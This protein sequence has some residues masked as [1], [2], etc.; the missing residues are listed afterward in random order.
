MLLLPC[1][2]RRPDLKFK[3]I[4]FDLDGV[5]VKEPSAWW[6]LHQAFG[7]YEV[8]K[9]NLRAYETG[10]I[11][12]PEFMRR[13]ISLWGR[14]NIREIKGILQKFTLTRGALEACHILRGRGYRLAILSAGIDILART[15]S[16]KLGIKIWAGNGLEIDDQGFLTGDGIFRVDLIAKHR[17]LTELIAPLGIEISE[18]VAVGDSKYDVPLMR[19][20]GA[21][22]AFIRNNSAGSHYWSKPWHRIFRLVDLPKVL[23]EIEQKNL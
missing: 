3:M 18:T 7:S 4:V 13:D 19:A 17:A 21:G 20:S 16:K 9:V 11:D 5:L 10:K 6:T 8:S 22:I 23:L 1:L 12:Y 15:V 14:R 2:N